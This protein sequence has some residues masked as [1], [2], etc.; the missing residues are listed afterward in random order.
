MK[1]RMCI[2]NDNRILII[3]SGYLSRT[4]CISTQDKDGDYSDLTEYYTHPEQNLEFKQIGFSKKDPNLLYIAC[5]RNW[6]WSTLIILFDFKKK[7]V[8]TTL[9]IDGQTSFF[10]PLSL[11]FA[12]SSTD[13]TKKILFYNEEFEKIAEKE[14]VAEQGRIVPLHKRNSY[15]ALVEISPGKILYPKSV[16]SKTMQVFNYENN[17]NE[18]DQID[19]EG[20]IN[21]IYLL[22]NNKV[23]VVS[24]DIIK[25]FNLDTFELIAKIRD[26]IQGK[27]ILDICPLL[28]GGMMVVFDSVK[29]GIVNIDSNFNSSVIP[30]SRRNIVETLKASKTSNKF[31]SIDRIQKISFWEY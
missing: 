10:C 28:D 20:K 13:N 14:L 11:G 31:F 27:M 3:S 7:S 30:Y 2:T 26:N 21:D 16:E 15:K 22:M 18:D 24:E 19:V 9:K 29:G 6:E 12:F 23:A 1:N 4:L 25:I 17:Q 5:N 8:I